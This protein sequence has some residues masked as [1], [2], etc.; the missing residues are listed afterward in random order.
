MCANLFAMTASASGLLSTRMKFRP[1]SA[2]A[3][4]VVP[5]PAK[6]SKTVSPGFDEAAIMRR[7]IPSGFCVG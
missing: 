3:I 5:L 6:K 1:S 4:P 2:A 7:R